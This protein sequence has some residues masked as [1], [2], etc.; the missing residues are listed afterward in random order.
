MSSE[1][2]RDQLRPSQIQ[3][4]L[5]TAMLEL[6]EEWDS[7]EEAP[8]HVN[9]ALEHIQTAMNLLSDPEVSVS[10]A[11]PSDPDWPVTF[12]HLNPE[13][14]RTPAISRQMVAWDYDSI[15]ALFEGNTDYCLL[16]QIAD[17]KAVFFW[18]RGECWLFTTY[19]SGPWEQTMPELIID[20]I[21]ASAPKEPG[22]E[23]LL[24]HRDELDRDL[25]TPIERARRET[26]DH[27]TQ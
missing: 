26:T 21:G 3:Y 6:G 4:Q 25:E 19:P 7:A 14:S 24:L 22:A 13:L 8:L 15:A 16:A 23:P 18:E 1:T 11:Q 2:L 9:V 17:N 12:R 5:L 27:I 20:W 10:D